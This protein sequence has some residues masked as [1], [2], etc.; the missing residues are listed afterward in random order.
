MIFIHVGMVY[1]ISEPD[2]E[3]VLLFLILN[4]EA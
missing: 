4:S 1:H 2:F 3:L